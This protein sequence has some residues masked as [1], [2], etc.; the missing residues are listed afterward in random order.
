VYIQFTKLILND[1]IHLSFVTIYTVLNISCR[2]LT[3][4]VSMNLMVYIC[5]ANE[6]SFLP[7]L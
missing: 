5:T 7:T 2:H 4:Y 3:G 6:L 1:Y